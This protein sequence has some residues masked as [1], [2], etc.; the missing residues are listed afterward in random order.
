M[1]ILHRNC[2]LPGIAL[3]LFAPL[4]AHGDPYPPSPVISEVIFDFSTHD[5]R[6]PGSDN[7]PVTWADDDNQYT[8]WGDGGGFGGTNEVGRVSLGVGRIEGTRTSYETFN[9]FGGHAP[10]NQT[11]IDGKSYGILSLS[12][13]LYMWVT[14]GGWAQG[15]EEARIYQSTDH[16]AS[17][18]RADWSFPGSDGITAPTFLQFGRDYQ[19]ARDGYVY[20]YANHIKDTSSLLVQIP[21]EI[22]LMRV[23]VDGLM[24]R[25]RYEFF[26]GVDGSGTPVWTRDIQS[27]VPV[28]SDSSGVGWNCSASYNPGL[29]RYLLMTEH[30]STFKGN[31]GI[32]DAPNPWGPWTTALYTSSFGS[33][34]VETTTFFWNFSNKWLSADGK[35][36]VMIFTGVSSN[37]SWNAVRGSFV[38]RNSSDVLP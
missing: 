22:A 32:F 10:E 33:P 12:G 17:W 4:L 16:G 30:G 29:K 37:D 23:P 18:S 36:F 13:T 20:V 2:L 24:S 35:D 1:G 34:H 6:A 7:W 3:L 25:D 15:Y 31:L 14:P 21:G 8:S 19:G 38:T 27:R 26:M 5:R 9:V 11:T 28:F